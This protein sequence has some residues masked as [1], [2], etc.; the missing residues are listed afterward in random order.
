[1][2]KFITYFILLFSILTLV[3]IVFFNNPI[4]IYFNSAKDVYRIL[5]LSKN[6][7]NSKT[8]LVGD[9]VCKQFLEGYNFEDIFCLC[10]NQAYEV[11]GNFL[12][13]KE[14]LNNGSTFSEFILVINPLTLTSSLNQQYTYNYF[15]KPFKNTLN[16][17]KFLEKETNEYL[18]INFSNSFEPKYLFSNKIFFSNT[19]IFNNHKKTYEISKV[20]YFYINKI[21]ELCY[22]NNIEFKI[23]LPPLPEDFLDIILKFNNK[24]RSEFSDYFNSGLFYSDL[25]SND[26]VH[27]VNPKRLTSSSKFQNYAS[28]IFK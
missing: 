16:N 24:D 11:V 4:S 18:K 6:K 2:K 19:K 23:I 8:I 21:K 14:L 13:L 3:I 22:Q 26:G 7:T 10:S 1:M 27:H 28:N 15:Y 20:N 25:D 12:I 9:S 17:F 5:N